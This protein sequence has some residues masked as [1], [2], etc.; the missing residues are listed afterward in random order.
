MTRLNSKLIISDHGAYD[1]A[2]VPTNLFHETKVSNKNFISHKFGI[3][4]NQILISSSLPLFYR[5]F[6]KKKWR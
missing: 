4:K 2:I 1:P 3:K 5:N 6:K